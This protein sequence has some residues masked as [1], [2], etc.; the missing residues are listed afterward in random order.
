MKSSA[1]KPILSVFLIVMILLTS[2]PLSIAN[3]ATQGDFT[4]TVSNSTVSIT[5][6]SGSASEVEVPDNIDGYPVVSIGYGAFRKNTTLK[7]VS[8]PDTLDYIGGSAFEECT[9]LEGI[10]IPEN[11][12][13]VSGS[14]FYKCSSLAEVTIPDS[15]E[16]IYSSSFDRTAFYNNSENWENGVLYL[17]PYLLKV[18]QNISGNYTVREGTTVVASSAFM[19]CVNLVS[20]VFPDGV[21]II[22]SGVF[23]DCHNLKNVTLPAS[24]KRIGAGAFSTATKI[25]NIYITDIDAWCDIDFEDAGANPFKY[26]KNLYINNQ[27]TTELTLSEGIDNIKDYTFYGMKN[28]KSISLPQSVSAIGTEAFYNCSLLENINIPDNVESIGTSAFSGCKSIK[29]I[30]IPESC[31]S[32]ADGAFAYCSALEAVEL[33][34]NLA[35]LGSSAFSDCSNLKAIE[36]PDTIDII[37][38]Y[39][40]SGCTN[41]ST[42]ILPDTI[43]SIGENAFLECSKLTNFHIPES[44][45]SIGRSAFQKCSSLQEITIPQ[46]IITVNAT[47]FWY[48]TGAKKI[49]IPD[50][51]TTIDTGAF[52]GCKSLTSI[53]IPSGVESI[54]GGAFEQCTSLYDIKIPQSVTSVSSNSFYDTKYYNTASN[55]K[56]GV[57][58]IGDILMK[59]D[60]T[61]PENYSVEPGTRLIAER[62]FSYI[63]TLKRVTIPQGVSVICQSAFSGCSN[64]NT[65]I[66][67]VSVQDIGYYNFSDCAKTFRICGE[68]GSYAEAYAAKQKLN[69]TTL[70]E[71]LD[72]DTQIKILTSREQSFTIST[73]SD[74]DTAKALESKTKFERFSVLYNIFSDENIVDYQYGSGVTVKIPVEN[75]NFKIYHIASNNTTIPVQAVYMDGCLSFT[76]SKIGDFAVTEV[77]PPTSIMGDVDLDGKINIKDASLIQKHVAK[78]TVITDPQADLADLDNDVNVT[79][80]DASAVQKIIAGIS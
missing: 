32:I 20:V 73:P 74:T 68:A 31:L 18:S 21:Y 65:A 49:S 69:F 40:F 24:I 12:K 6:Y 59:A 45:Q 60:S 16:T 41:L 71:F 77:I 64:L 62:A 4:Y 22:G 51:V 15:V 44:V 38:S 79:V 34:K 17:G 10:V 1:T 57:L 76:Y 19:D 47:T 23:G 67:P 3:A 25:E 36:I 78:I 26:G 39:L 43:A 8:L 9:S 48:C 50:S 27:L 56:N 52:G 53:D 37:N 5:K 80:K 72:A 66:V 55:W 70:S 2:L 33:P 54:V 13:T 28:V 63:D 61:V 58:Y 35:N 42:V 14:A 29:N 11:V 30:K 75:E 7:K 46:G